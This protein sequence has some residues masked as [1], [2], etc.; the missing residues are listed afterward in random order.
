M[1][2]GADL[3]AQ[4]EQIRGGDAQEEPA[5]AGL[6]VGYA[7]RQRDARAA[8]REFRSVRHEPHLLRARSHDRCRHRHDAEKEREPEPGRG[9]G[10]APALDQEGAERRD[11]HAAER[12][13][14]RG[15]GEGERPTRLEPARHDGRRG[16]QA[17]EAIT[18]AVHQME[19][20]ELPR[21]LQQGKRAERDRAHASSEDHDQAGI[22][23]IHQPPG[24]HAARAG[25]NE[26]ARGRAA[27]ERYRKPALGHEGVEQ[28]RKVV[29][30]QARGR[31]Q[32]EADGVND[33]PTVEGP[34]APINHDRS[35]PG[36][37]KFPP[38]R[39]AA[40][41]RELTQGYAV[42]FRELPPEPWQRRRPP[43]RRS[44]SSLRSATRGR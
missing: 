9:P 11:Q 2:D 22:D 23:A 25:G 41:D 6:R 14:G 39:N 17:A 35:S 29:E 19:R 3:R 32:H 10:D 8:L 43:S 27:R 21:P 28:H 36:G 20:I 38:W 7:A 40:T 1:G 30:S 24:E 4:A 12:Q 16:H 26:E 13:S 44:R 34:Q 42:M 33:V 18:E 15:D 37:S 31:H 5:A